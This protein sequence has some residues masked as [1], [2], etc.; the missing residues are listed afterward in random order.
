MYKSSNLGFNYRKF[1]KTI[2]DTEFSS[3]FIVHHIDQ[4]QLNHKHS[5]LVI[6]P[7]KLHYKIHGLLKRFK[8]VE[9]KEVLEKCGQDVNTLCEYFFWLG[10]TTGR[11]EV[12]IYHDINDSK[13][14]IKRINE[15]Y[16]EV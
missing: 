1:I 11:K 2:T 15:R 7:R 16:K 14:A 6:L 3:E 13:N 9:P 10:Y 12:C 8:V 4:N 5:N